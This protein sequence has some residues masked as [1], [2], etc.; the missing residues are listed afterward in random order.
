MGDQNRA[1][2]ERVRP[3]LDAAMADVRA[4][5]PNARAGVRGA[6]GGLGATPLSGTCPS[7]VPDPKAHR[8][9]HFLFHAMSKTSDIMVLRS[10]ERRSRTRR[11]AWG[12]R[13]RGRAGR[14]PATPAARDPCAFAF[15]SAARGLLRVVDLAGTPRGPRAPHET[16]VGWIRSPLPG[17]ACRVPWTAA[18]RPGRGS[19]PGALMPFPAG[20]CRPGAVLS[21]RKT[22]E[23]TPARVPATPGLRGSTCPWPRA[24]AK[25]DG[26]RA[27]SARDSRFRRVAVPAASTRSSSYRPA[28]EAAA[29]RSGIGLFGWWT[30]RRRARA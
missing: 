14:A 6:R 23:T 24:R 25:L 13:W 5:S 28:L 30:A 29:A 11:F 8:P 18:R 1:V 10:A 12:G 7:R 3:D 21:E 16:S 9:G 26:A 17:A 15:T 22:E 20:R 4:T 27:A 2:Y 19:Q